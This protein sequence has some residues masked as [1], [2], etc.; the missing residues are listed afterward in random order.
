MQLLLRFVLL[1]ITF[2]YIIIY[3]LHFLIQLFAIANK[4]CSLKSLIM[5]SVQWCSEVLAACDDNFKEPVF[6]RKVKGSGKIAIVREPFHFQEI[7]NNF[8]NAEDKTKQGMLMDYFYL[9][10]Y[11]QDDVFCERCQK[12]KWVWENHDFERTVSLPE[13]LQYVLES[14][15]QDLSGDCFGFYISSILRPVRC[16]L[17]AMLEICIT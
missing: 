3:H 17:W 6:M 7:Y 2:E 15:R 9:Q 13:N 10:Y 8:W 14:Q 5:F 16:F 11:G 1:K 4:I 12:L